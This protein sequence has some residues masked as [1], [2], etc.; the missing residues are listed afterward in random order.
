MRVRVRGINIHEGD[1]QGWGEQAYLCLCNMLFACVSR[2]HCVLPQLKL[3]KS[4]SD[5]VA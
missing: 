1:W 3:L 2:S 5:V 4:L